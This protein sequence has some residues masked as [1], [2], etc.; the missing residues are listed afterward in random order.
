MFLSAEYSNV[1]S[2]PNS[3]EFKVQCTSIE[4]EPPRAEGVHLLPDDDEDVV[5]DDDCVE[6]YPL[7]LE[8]L[9]ENDD[10]Y[11]DMMMTD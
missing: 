9:E 3:E 11:P 6:E 1:T 5:N 4:K 10:E 2:L 8:Q 7:E